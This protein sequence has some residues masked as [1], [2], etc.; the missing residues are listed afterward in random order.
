MDEDERQ[1]YDPTSNAVQ[2]DQKNM[3]TVINSEMGAIGRY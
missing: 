2:Y 1:R 3:P